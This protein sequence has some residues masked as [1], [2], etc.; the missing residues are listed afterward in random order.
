MHIDHLEALFKVEKNYW[1]HIAKR[2]LIIKLLLKNFPPP[3]TLIE[4][5]IGGGYNLLAFK[6]LGY[7]T[8]GF[9]II[10]ESVDYCRNAGLSDTAV[11]DITKPWPVKNNSINVVIL[12]DVLEHIEEPTT[13]LINAEKTL[14]K[15]GGIIFTVPA[16][17]WLMGP[18]DKMLG[19]HRRYNMK[20]IKHQVQK[21]GLKIDRLSFW[22]S[23]SLPL[24][25]LLRVSQRMFNLS[26][27]PEFPSVSQWTNSLLINCARIERLWLNHKNI[28][29]GLSLFG[30]LK[31]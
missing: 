11:H 19:H 24:A 17:T 13:V 9:D 7:Q 31:K 27:K 15:Q 16:Y 4:G 28:P 23:F 5:G 10:P 25:L 6:K 8:T 2:D 20:D 1:W 3:A 22:N 21:A 18:W 14:D 29:A 30:V 12:L 26:V